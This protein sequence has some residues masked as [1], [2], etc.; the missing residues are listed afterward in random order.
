MKTDITNSQVETS[1]DHSESDQKVN[2]VPL[3][4]KKKGE[5]RYGYY[6]SN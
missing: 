1:L 2:S 4:Q 5:Y 3:P 6:K